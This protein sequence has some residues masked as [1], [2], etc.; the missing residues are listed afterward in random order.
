MLFLMKRRSVK[1]S[2]PEK[3]KIASA[4]EIAVL[5]MLLAAIIS[6]IFVVSPDTIFYGRFPA[7]EDVNNPPI[8]DLPI[9]NSTLG[10]NT[11]LE[12]LTV[13]NQSTTDVDGDAVTNIINW[14]KNGVPLTVLNMPFE[15]NDST[16]AKDYSGYGNDGDV[17]AAVWNPTGG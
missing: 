15:L 8:H 6:I 16:T 14:Y 17:V 1:Q 10:M 4:R 13:Y 3:V 11:I 7:V 12:N 9:L 2:R 5:L